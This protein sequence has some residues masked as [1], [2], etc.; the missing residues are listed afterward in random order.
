VQAE[1]AGVASTPTVAASIPA[2]PAASA[3]AAPVAQTGKKEGG[4]PLIPILAGSIVLVLVA[5]LAVWKMQDGSGGGGDAAKKKSSALEPVIAAKG[6][7]A[8]LVPAG[9]FPFGSAKVKVKSPAFYLDRT[10]VSNKA[11]GEF[12]AATGRALPEE[13][14]SGAPTLP[15]V[16]VSLADATEFCAWAGKRLPTDREWEKAARG[17]DGRSYPWG[18]APD[19]SRAN[20]ADNPTAGKGPMPVDAM[21]NGI[22]P[23][24]HLNLIG[25]VFE[26]IEHPHTPSAQAVQFFS[27]FMKPAPTV[28]E[29]WHYVKGGAF[30]RK[31]AE[32]IAYEWMSVPARLKMKSIGFRCAQ[33]PPAPE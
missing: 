18:D 32:G 21:D 31:L 25:N 6:G 1:L 30:D 11:Y 29:P 2:G 19:P 12:A 27:T 28:N 10:E 26:W 4:L 3:P 5:I 9:E 7:D 24:K 20:V 13:F 14:A 15:V 33:D 23:Y 22:G 8:L 17:P 16:N